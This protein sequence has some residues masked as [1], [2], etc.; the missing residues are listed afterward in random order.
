MKSRAIISSAF[1]IGALACGGSAFVAGDRAGNNGGASGSG[2]AGAKGSGGTTERGGGGNETGG[3][4]GSAGTTRS[5][6]STGSGGSTDL[7]GGSTG[8]GGSTHATGGSSG[9]GGSTGSGG[10]TGVGGST[11]VADAGSAC[12][13][14]LDSVNSLL[15]L[16]ETC[17][18]GVA[19]ECQT[20]V[21]TRCGCQVLVAASDS[22]AAKDYVNALAKYNADCP[23]LLCPLIACIVPTSGS[24]GAPSA[25]GVRK[26]VSTATV[27]DAAV[28]AQ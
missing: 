17:K 21:T 6:G 23:R 27:L 22:V 25:N 20:T 19:T 3:M 9:A 26:C 24:C 5:G 1:V 16:A 28:G 15:V 18:G 11:G 12:T 10:T 7:T 8:S 13:A 4:P 14:L 2:G